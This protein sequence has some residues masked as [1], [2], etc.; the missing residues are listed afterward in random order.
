[1]ERTLIEMP[2]WKSKGYT[3]QEMKDMINHMKADVLKDI[4]EQMKSM[5]NTGMLGDFDSFMDFLDNVEEDDFEDF[6]DNRID[7]KKL[8]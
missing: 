7:K 2:S 5:G 3:L 6:F 4:E 1:M 8:N